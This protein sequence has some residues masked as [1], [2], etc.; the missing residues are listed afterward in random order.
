MKR[1]ITMKIASGL[2]PRRLRAEMR[3]SCSCWR[4][5]ATEYKDFGCYSPESC[6]YPD[7]GAAAAR[8]VAVG[9]V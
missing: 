2:R 9:R 1:T 8:A 6:D 7:F 4:S 5:W 3:S